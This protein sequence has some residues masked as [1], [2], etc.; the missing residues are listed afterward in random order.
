MGDSADELDSTWNTRNKYAADERFFF[1]IK[2]NGCEQPSDAA[3]A[4]WCVE[5]NPPSPS[6]LMSMVQLVMTKSSQAHIMQTGV[7]HVNAKNWVYT[8]QDRDHVISNK[9]FVECGGPL[10]KAAN[11]TF[12]KLSNKDEFKVTWT[13]DKG[14]VSK[15]KVKEYVLHW[16]VTLTGRVEKK[17]ITVS[18]SKT[19]YTFDPK[20]VMRFRESF[21]DVRSVELKWIAI[22]PKDRWRG[23]FKG[24]YYPGVQPSHAI[25]VR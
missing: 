24:I 4:F 7:R 13:L 2:E 23:P 3:E 25:W 6:S 1:D 5:D 17:T 15:I 16:V 10:H 12:Q 8:D 9:F 19:A 18:G 22:E 21:S 20:S 14:C 11:I